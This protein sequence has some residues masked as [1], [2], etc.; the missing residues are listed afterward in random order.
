MRMSARWEIAAAI[1]IPVFAFGL[2]WRM[3][4]VNNYALSAAAD[5]MLAIMAFDLVVLASHHTFESVVRDS[6]LQE[7]F[8]TMFVVFFSGTTIFWYT[9]S[10]RFEHE[11]NRGYSYLQKRYVQGRPMG[12]FL[13]GWAVVAAVLCVHIFPFVY[14]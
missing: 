12:P 13:V 11:M 10:L 2:N 6:L 14:R 4:E 5:F 3:R 9:L 7:Q 8:V 1:I